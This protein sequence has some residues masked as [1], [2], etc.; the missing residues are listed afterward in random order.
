[1]LLALSAVHWSCSASNK[2]PCDAS[3]ARCCALVLGSRILRR[4]AA[5]VESRS[6]GGIGERARSSQR[7]RL[8]SATGGA[9]VISVLTSALLYRLAGR[10]LC[11][12]RLSALT[13]PPNPLFTLGSGDTDSGEK[14][15]KKLSTAPRGDVCV[16]RAPAG[17]GACF[18]GG[19][20]CHY[21][22]PGH[23]QFRR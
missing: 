1:M 13:S 14:D 7:A 10:Q 16:S 19:R 15:R 22:A 3:G 11:A 8:N 6:A 2:F 21:G 12:S 20:L 17:R 9:G 4:P 18:F 5:R 23:H